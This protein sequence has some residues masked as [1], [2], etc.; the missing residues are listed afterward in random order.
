MSLRNPFKEKLSHDGMGG[1]STVKSGGGSRNSAATK[2]GVSLT[3]GV[4]DVQ[5]HS[6]AEHV[7]LYT[8]VKR[9]TIVCDITDSKIIP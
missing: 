8:V 2:S 9:S 5:D 7:G 3:S 6:T 1:G 4:T